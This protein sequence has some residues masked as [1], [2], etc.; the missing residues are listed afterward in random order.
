MYARLKHKVSRTLEECMLKNAFHATERLDNVCAIVV[1]VPEFAIMALV[2]PPEGVLLQQ[3]EL[4]EVC[5][6]TPSLVIRQRMAILLE[7]CVD[8]W[9][10]PVP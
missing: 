2:R 10:A 9:N 3:L 7:Q 1:E 4:L 6:H 8:A 5:A